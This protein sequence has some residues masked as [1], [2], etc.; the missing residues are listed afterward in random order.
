MRGLR[1][2]IPFL[3]VVALLPLLPSCQDDNTTRPPIVVVTPQAARGVIASTTLTG[4]ASGLLYAIPIQI[5]QRGVAD[6]TVDWTYDDSFIY[7]YF[8]Q[9]S[10]DFR[11]IAFHNCPL[12]LESETTKPKPRVLTTGTL[13]PGLYYLYIY[14]LAR[15]PLTGEGSDNMEAVSIQVG[16]TVAASSGRS[17]EV[18]QLGRPAVVSPPHP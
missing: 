9:T 17:G 18:I 1:S 7:V 2:R 4:F 3:A 10:C 6:I 13:D 14:N 16:L 12:L 11:Q 5:D 8:G 15:V